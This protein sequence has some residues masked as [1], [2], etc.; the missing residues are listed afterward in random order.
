MSKEKYECTRCSCSV[1]ADE[2]DESAEWFD[3]VGALCE[4]CLVEYK[5][6]LKKQKKLEEDEENDDNEFFEDDESHP[7]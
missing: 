2:V 3:D 4:Y 5:Q 6:E 7:F 1:P